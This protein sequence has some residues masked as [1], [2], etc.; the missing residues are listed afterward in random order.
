MDINIFFSS[1][2]FSDSPPPLTPYFFDIGFRRSS[3]V[4]KG[5]PGSFKEDTVKSK[6]Q[7][8]AIEN[9]IKKNFP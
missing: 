4:Y 8:R 9:S 7:F 2:E 1:G 5:D 6:R 3:I